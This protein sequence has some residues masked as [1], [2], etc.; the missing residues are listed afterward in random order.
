[1]MM[2][3]W[4]GG[5]FAK[6]CYTTVDIATIFV[7]KNQVTTCCQ[8]IIVVNCCISTCKTSL[9]DVM[10]PEVY[11]NDRRYVYLSSADLL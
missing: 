10:V 1:M 6:D 7:L 5:H 8:V 3:G 9:L 11:Q 4:F 2:V